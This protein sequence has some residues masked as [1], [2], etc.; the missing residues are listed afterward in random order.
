[1]S[2]KSFHL[3]I[4]NPERTFFDGQAVSVSG[5]NKSGAFDILPDHAH[6]ISLIDNQTV[7]VVDEQ[8]KPQA[9]KIARGLISAKENKVRVFVDL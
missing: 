6:F 9:F 4:S 1:M 5:K 2:T 3:L 8:G 7:N